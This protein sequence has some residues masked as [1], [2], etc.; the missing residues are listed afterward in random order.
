[1]GDFTYGR[2]I[3]TQF[4]SG[5]GLVIRFITVSDA[6]K[7]NPSEVFPETR[8]WWRSP[9]RQY[10]QRFWCLSS[11]CPPSGRLLLIFLNTDYVH[12][13]SIH[14]QNNSHFSIWLQILKYFIY[15]LKYKYVFCNKI[16]LGIIAYIT[17]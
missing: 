7:C 8:S 13:G 1:M 5:A 4:A 16:Y 9:Y 17:T 14:I 2:G 3:K 12:N 6:A 11:L 15:L 10:P